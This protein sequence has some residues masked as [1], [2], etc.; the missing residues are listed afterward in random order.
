[1]F[2]VTTAL[3]SSWD[4]S[5]ETLFLGRWCLPYP[6]PEMPPA[7]AWRVLPYPWD[8]R[9]LLARDAA[10]VW[11]ACERQLQYWGDRLNDAH[12][13][14]FPHRY[15]RIVL[16]PWLTQ[17]LAIV[18][19][20]RLC[21]ETAAASCSV[22]DTL[23][24]KGPEAD[25][26]PD[27]QCD[28]VDLL[29][30]DRY[31]HRI[32]ADIIEALRLFPYTTRPDAH[33]AC[34]R[35][36]QPA[37]PRAARR[38]L[39]VWNR[40]FAGAC[41]V[42]LQDT[43]LKL[44]GEVFL[45]LALGQPPVVF[46]PRASHERFQTDVARRTRLA[47]ASPA[48]D[49]FEA[50]L[51]VLVPRHLPRIFLE[52]FSRT[53]EQAL[54]MYP[55]RPRV[56]LTSRSHLTDDR[57]NLYAA[58][59]CVRGAKLGIIQHGG[60]YGVGLINHYEDHEKASADRY[61][62]WGWDDATGRTRPAPA[63]KL[64]SVR[65]KRPAPGGD[66]LSAIT[67]MPRYSYRLYSLPV[68]A[69]QVEAY[70]EDQCRFIAGLS[71]QAARIFRLRLY[72]SDYGLNEEQLFRDRFPNLALA[73]SRQP[74]PRQM[75]ESRLFICTYNSTM[76]LESFRADV[77]TIMFWNPRHWELRPAAAPYFEALS[78]AGV[79]HETP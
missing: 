32:Y 30:S 9:D 24:L 45:Q 50:L 33:M 74:F 66:I 47:D 48:R 58:E 29:P 70:L 51:R 77:P 79:F 42:V 26:P 64:L 56:L 78:R 4:K 49:P 28:F 35:P 53:R 15:W 61:F 39:D 67:L 72:V 52:G 40:I 73:D 1:M 22:D 34:A 65:R 36:S 6:R 37:K 75:A 60:H 31:N 17:F 44:R 2:L 8:D 69:G 11:D 63:P 13:L 10:L 38:C 16:G 20:R 21:L 62:T 12:G 59:Q 55:P 14:D 19:E 41:R 25:L 68:G 76:F 5:R 54:A 57:W 23:I 43:S 27:D 71:A 46:T 7:T 3:E 18:H